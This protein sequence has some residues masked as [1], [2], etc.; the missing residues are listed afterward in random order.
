MKCK[1]CGSPVRD[2]DMFCGECGCR[3]EPRK[4]AH[5]RCPSCGSP[6]KDEDMFCG[7]CGYKLDTP[8]PEFVPDI[9][10]DDILKDTIENTAGVKSTIPARKMAEKDKELYS[11]G[12]AF[13][14]IAGEL[15]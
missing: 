12:R 9:T 1:Q 10:A 11:E 3:L 8:L 2:E 15:D 14:K 7:E 5:M 6:V 13:L 4:D